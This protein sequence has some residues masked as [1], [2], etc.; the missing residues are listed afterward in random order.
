MSFAA[1][2]SIAVQ[3]LGM[4]GRIV[5]APDPA[6]LRR[7]SSVLLAA[8]RPFVRGRWGAK[9]ALTT[10]VCAIHLREMVAQRPSSPSSRP[11]GPRERARAQVI[12]TLPTQDRIRR[13]V[14]L[15]ALG[16]W[17][18]GRL[19]PYQPGRLPNV[20]NGIACPVPTP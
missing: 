9:S 16:D 8:A 4:N 20:A 15:E 14:I 10:S 2:P 5:P 1:G 12:P 3:T 11:P 19:E 17:R 6:P 13:L 18:S 7:A